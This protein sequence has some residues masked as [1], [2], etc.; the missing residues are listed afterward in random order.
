MLG[1]GNGDGFAAPGESFGILLPD[2]DSFR[3]AQLFTNDACIDNT[4][5]QSDSWTEY[6]RA[7]ASIQYSVPRI[8]PD[9]QPG[10]VIHMLA[11]VL[12]PDYRMKYASVEFPVWWRHPEDAYKK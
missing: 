11:R 10:H 1:E 6:D 9:C 2:G 8:L 4:V 12:L 3:V 7:G 5:R